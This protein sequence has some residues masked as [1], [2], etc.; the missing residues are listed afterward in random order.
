MGAGLEYGPSYEGASKTGFSIVPSDFDV[1]RPGE[2]AGFS[3]PDEAFSYTLFDM[4]GLSFRPAANYRG[5]RS[6]SDE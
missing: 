6:R 4:H 1:R 5:G 2:A 3:A